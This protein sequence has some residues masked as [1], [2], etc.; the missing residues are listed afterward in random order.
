VLICSELGNEE[1]SHIYTK[2]HC[3]ATPSLAREGVAPGGAFSG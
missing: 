2:G 3:G 1:N